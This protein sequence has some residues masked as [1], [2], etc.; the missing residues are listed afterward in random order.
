MSDAGRTVTVE[1]RAR[2][3]PGLAV[4]LTAAPDERARCTVQASVEDGTLPLA[5]YLDVDGD[6]VDTEVGAAAGHAVPAAHVPPGRHVVT[7]RAVDAAG[8]WGGA[9]AVIEVPAALVSRADPRR[10]GCAAAFPPRARDCAG[11]ALALPEG[12]PPAFV[13]ESVRLL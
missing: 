8:R 7:V 5:L 4:S 11:R 12:D 1:P 9:S 13:G 3:E 10:G 6:L 2:C